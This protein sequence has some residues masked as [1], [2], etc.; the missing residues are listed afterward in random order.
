MT[1]KALNLKSTIQFTFAGML[2]AIMSS[3]ATIF[4]LTLEK[5]VRPKSHERE[6]PFLA[7]KQKA[8]NFYKVFSAAYD[9]LNPPFYTDEMRSKITALIKGE[10]AYVLDVGCGTGYTTRGILNG[11]DIC[12]VVGLDMNPVQLGRAVK[13]LQLEKARVAIAM[14]DAEILPFT[15]ETFDAVV[16][17]GAIEYFPSPNR[18]VKEMTRVCKTGGVV[19]I[20]VPEVAWFKKFGLDK[21]F[22][23][24][25]ILEVKELFAQAGLR[26]EKAGLIGVE[27]VFGTRNYVVVG[28]GSKIVP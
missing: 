24:P 9:I 15:D 17:V 28:A 1:S 22:Y 8:L 3:V 18:A 21:F 25:S 16:S 6:K 11:K 27:T 26:E 5:R 14:G 4:V 12:E 10:G 2:M 23:T 7:D 19:V 13:N 20:G